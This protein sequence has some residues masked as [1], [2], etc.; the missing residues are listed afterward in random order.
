M[1]KRK[2][3]KKAVTIKRGT[4]RVVKGKVRVCATKSGKIYTSVVGRKKA[5]RKRKGTTAGKKRKKPAKC[6]TKPTIR[7]GVCSCRG[8]KTKK[9]PKGK[10]FRLKVA[11]C[12][13]PKR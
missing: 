4:C 10:I 11:F 3:A 13:K 6:A 8:K 1:A 2:K 7:K 9:N 12:R 5:T